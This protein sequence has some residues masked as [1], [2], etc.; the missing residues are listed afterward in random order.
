MRGH[1]LGAMTRLLPGAVLVI[2]MYVMDH[3]LQEPRRRL[4]TTPQR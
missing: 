4:M 1:T 3:E 2:I